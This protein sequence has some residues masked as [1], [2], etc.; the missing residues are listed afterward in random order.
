MC[1]KSRDDIHG[2]EVV[3]IHVVQGAVLVGRHGANV[4]DIGKCWVKDP[5]KVEGEIEGAV[6]RDCAEESID[7]I[8]L[9]QGEGVAMLL[10]EI[11]VDLKHVDLAE[12]VEDSHGDD[13]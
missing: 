11:Q 8:G 3:V 1:H 13:Q 7:E 10:L 4:G 2:G 6:D 12:V 5:V 9:F